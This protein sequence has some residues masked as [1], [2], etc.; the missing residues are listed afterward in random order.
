MSTR[1]EL[2]QRMTRAYR[3]ALASLAIVAIGLLALN[4]LMDD[5][6]GA[7]S[8]VSAIASEQ[9]MLTQ[10]IAMKAIALVQP[11]PLPGFASL[12]RDIAADTGRLRANHRL[13]LVE[14]GLDPADAGAVAPG[15]ADGVAAVFTESPYALDARLDGFAAETEALLDLPLAGIDFATIEP[16]IAAARFD[17]PF[18]LDAAIAGFTRR[19]EA[20]LQQMRYLHAFG[21]SVWAALLIG[22][23]VLVFRPMVRRVE[24]TTEALEAARS[25]MEHGALHDALTGLPNRR[26]LAE[27]LSS[28][29]ARA[30][31]NGDV[32]G[33]LHLDLDRFKQVNDTLGHG[34]GDAVLVEATRR[35]AKTLRKSDFLARVGG[36]E[37]LIV[38]PNVPSIEGLAI[39]SERMITVISEPIEYEGTA[40]LIGTSIGIALAPPQADLAPERLVMNADAALY[41]AKEAG[42]GTYRYFGDDATIALPP[43][44]EEEPAATGAQAP[45]TLR[46]AG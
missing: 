34:A 5:H 36:D 41:A 30:R 17:L 12:R 14:A 20:L 18:A 11:V 40:C 6:R 2:G 4:R 7:L 31:R 32:V 1:T 27:H 45:V 3:W 35:M 39:L 15:A 38:A 21:L 33:L 43:S 16:V 23:S 26:Y 42:R 8:R 29:L 37:F 19:E 44:D 22:L 46:A 25:R 13:L 24:D 9:H 10:R 28:T